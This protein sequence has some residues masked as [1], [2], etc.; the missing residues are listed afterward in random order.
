[1]TMSQQGGRLTLL[2]TSK[3]HCG[4]FATVHLRVETFLCMESHKCLSTCFDTKNVLG[5]QSQAGLNETL[6]VSFYIIAIF[7]IPFAWKLLCNTIYPC[8]NTH[9]SSQKEE[10]LDNT[11]AILPIIPEL[12]V[13]GELVIIVKDIIE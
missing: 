3:Q 10:S 7:Y 5:E 11:E 8:S 1:M 6:L 13:K 9:N 12:I 4:L 2:E